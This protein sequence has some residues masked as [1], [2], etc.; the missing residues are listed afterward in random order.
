M[1]Y[2]VTTIGEDNNVDSCTCANVIK[3]LD[4]YDRFGFRDCEI[5]DVCDRMN[6]LGMRSPKKK[7]NPR[8][9]FYFTE[10]GWKEV[11]LVIVQEMREMGYY[12]RVEKKKNPKA[13]DAAYFDSYQ[14]ALLPNRRR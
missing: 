3:E 13:S 12:V 9:R 14:V 10:K 7:V 8:A 2:R 4:S 1:I 5:W 6:K 11:G